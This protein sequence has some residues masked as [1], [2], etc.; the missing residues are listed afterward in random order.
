[1]PGP[2]VDGNGPEEG[3]R[4]PNQPK[5]ATMDQTEPTPQQRLHEMLNQCYTLKSLL[6]DANDRGLDAAAAFIGALLDKTLA[7]AG[8]FCQS[9]V[10]VDVPVVHS[11]PD[12]V[13][14]QYDI[15]REPPDVI[16][17]S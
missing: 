15:V 10:G 14:G 2:A 16:L 8:A 3:T 13:T 5:E 9:L 11:V 4:R 6:K 17:R 12:T 1:M 7:D